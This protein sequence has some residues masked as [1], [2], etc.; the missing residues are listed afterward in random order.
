MYFYNLTANVGINN[1]SSWFSEISH[2]QKDAGSGPE[3]LPIGVAYPSK[4]MK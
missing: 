1:L 3:I 2:S 4:F